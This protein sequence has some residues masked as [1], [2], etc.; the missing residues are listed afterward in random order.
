[1]A[2][3]LRLSKLSSADSK[4]LE[5]SRKRPTAVSLD[6]LFRAGIPKDDGGAQ[7]LRNA[8]FLHRELRLRVAQRS[9]E[10]D[11]LPFG[12]SSR[13]QIVK[14]R[15]YYKNIFEGLDN[16][17]P[18]MTL[19][20]E[21]R[22]TNALETVVLSNH[23]EVISNVALGVRAF[24]RD[25]GNGGFTQAVREEVDLSLNKFFTARIG[26]RFLIEHHMASRVKR[27]GY[28]GIIAQQCRPFEVVERA[29]DE[30]SYTARYHRGAA[31]K[32]TLIGDRDI[33]ITYVPYH[34]HYIVSELLKNAMR[35]TLDHH[36][37]DADDLPDVKVIIARGEH[38]VT[39]K[40]A[41]EGGG[42]H[43][44][45]VERCWTYLH[46]TAP[47]PAGLDS[48]DYNSLLGASSQQGGGSSVGALAG[49]GF[50]LPLSRLY[51]KYFGGN[52]NLMSMEGHGTDAYVHLNR[53]GTDCENLP[54]LVLNSPSSG[55]SS[56]IES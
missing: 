55:T 10:L 44:R 32:V 27:S 15:Q 8:Q 3:A 9:V 4:I 51:C 23:A 28:S 37:D 2:A 13:P 52:L 40:I 30:V 36:G 43:H 35:A 33:Q 25:M 42:M 24:R 39:I 1:M 17:P 21:L 7:R 11:S 46:S 34:I 26:I 48:D 19:E 47:Q 18:P 49:Y 20:D 45:D 12:L 56:H 41:D 6:N 22:F 38:D 50:G 31:P 29:V 54:S 14:V 5:W 16:L 53:L